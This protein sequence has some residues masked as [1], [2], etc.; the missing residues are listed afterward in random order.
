[1]AKEKMDYKKMTLD[2]MLDWLEKN[3]TEKEQIKFAKVALVENEEGKRVKRTREAKSYFYETYKNEIEFIN[4]PK[5]KEKKKNIVD[6]LE[7]LLNKSTD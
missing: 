4:A 7:A 2:S 5:P 3:K 1:M 6:R